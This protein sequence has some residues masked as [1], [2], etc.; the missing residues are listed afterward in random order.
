[1]PDLWKKCQ[2]HHP[3]VYLCLLQSPFYI[4][5]SYSMARNG[6]KCL[7]VNFS[8]LA[9]DFYRALLTFKCWGIFSRNDYVLQQNVR[10]STFD[11][12]Y[13]LP[14]GWMLASDHIA[15][16]FIPL[17]TYI[18]CP[19]CCQQLSAMWCK[20]GQNKVKQLLQSGRL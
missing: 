18:D 5:L 3:Q 13:R 10:M 6:T 7:S 20:E 19:H 1:M 11:S 4:A 2:P 12:P 8:G 14:A 9:P 17:T 15:N 16:G